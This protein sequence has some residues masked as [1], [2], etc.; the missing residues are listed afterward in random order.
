MKATNRKTILNLGIILLISIG[1]TFYFASG[2]LNL[3]NSFLN[4]L[5]G[6]LIGISIAFG[7]SLIT[8][9]IFRNESAYEQPTKNFVIAVVAV[10][11]FI[12]VDVIVVNTFWFGITQG[13]AI[14]QLFSSPFGMYTMTVELIIGLLI[15]LITLSRFF[16]RDLKKYY[17]RVA[18][19]ENQLTQY[20]Y[21]TLKNQLNPHFLFNSLNTLSGLIYIDVDKA[22]AFI[23]RLSKLYRYILEIQ[24][25]EV[26]PIETE[27]ELAQDFLYLNNIRFNQYVET[28]INLD[29]KEGYLVPMS[30]QLLIENAFKHNIISES[31]P[32]NIEISRE[33]DY[34]QV[35]NNVQLKLEKEP[36]HEL[37]LN[38]LKERYAVLTDKLVK[39]EESEGYFTV[40]V[41]ILIKE[42]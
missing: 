11:A 1:C 20:R 3:Y 5:Y 18:E 41:P 15:Y 9:Y 8:R 4:I 30:L 34:I 38:N 29:S 37:G 6:I 27:L 10:T 21:D 19:V 32:L 16:T 22:D 23:H 7:C 36:S 14:G 40:Q 31:S 13:V 25:V 12:V 17:K 42:D 26:V 35:K 2:D 39:I 28:S 33:G 24:R